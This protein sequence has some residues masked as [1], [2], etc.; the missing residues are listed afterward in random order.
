LP[1]LLAPP[2][3]NSF[4]RG[5]KRLGS[6]ISLQREIYEITGI[7]IEVLRARGNELSDFSVK[8]RMSWA[9]GRTTSLEEDRVYCLLGLFG[10]FL[11]PIY[12]EGERHTTLRLIEQLQKRPRK[13]DLEAKDY[14]GK[15]PLCLAAVH[16]NHTIVKALLRTIPPG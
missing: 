10:G 14:E 13:V 16:G 7:P 4:S 3:V 11:S 15:T 12:G 9:S 2:S 8:E 5:G 6:I 1:E